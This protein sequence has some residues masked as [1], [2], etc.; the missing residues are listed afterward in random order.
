MN[1]RPDRRSAAP[2]SSRAP[3]VRPP[4]FR[5]PAI[6]S[7]APL[8]GA[9][10]YPRTDAHTLFDGMPPGETKRGVSP[11]AG[12]DGIGCPPG[13]SSAAHPWLPGGAE[14][15]ADVRPWPPL[16]R[17]AMKLCILAYEGT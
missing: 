5:L 8:A 9:A 16:A 7:S 1:V 17:P 13:K 12:G 11:A 14:V 10:H 2:P 3:P 4:P 15:R 6:S